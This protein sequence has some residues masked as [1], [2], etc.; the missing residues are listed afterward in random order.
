M[1]KRHP[2]KLLFPALRVFLLI[3]LAFISLCLESRA[4]DGGNFHLNIGF[5]SR[6]FVNVPREDV[7]IAIQVLARK[8][9]VKTVGSADSRIY[10]SDSEIERALKARTLDMV[11][12][13]PE[14]FL[15]LRDQTQLEPM[16]VTVTG[17]TSELE[18]LLLAR[19]D[20]GISR[21]ADLRN[22]TIALPAENSQF[23]TIYRTWLENM[24]MK[25]GAKSAPT[26]FSAIT[27]T[28]GASQAV[29]SAFFRKTD[30]C[31]V[32]SNAFDVLN[33]LN[34]QLSRDLRVIESIDRLVG[35]IVAVRQ[36]LPNERKE[37]VRQTLENLHK[38]PDG[39]QVLVLFQL[40][41]IREFRSDNLKATEAMLAENKALKKRVAN[42]R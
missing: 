42:R 29:M 18:L 10:D 12:L 36:D 9:A 17:K 30:A 24:V 41:G 14:Q 13:T 23:G 21:F 4:G 25:E 26:F 2:A 27:E 19:K 5:S 28:R 35:G 6:V 20:Y 3:S 1:V 31:I 22:R 8:I 15:H 39:K 32:S 11:A 34:P 7:K 37:K 33:E 38:D 16:M 40:S